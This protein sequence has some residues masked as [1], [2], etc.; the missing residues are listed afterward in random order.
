[1]ANDN[2]YA[3]LKFCNEGRIQICWSRDLNLDAGTDWHV[4]HKQ[5]TFFPSFFLFFSKMFSN[6][7]GISRT[8][9]KRGHQIFVKVIIFVFVFVDAGAVLWDV[10]SHPQWFVNKNRV[11]HLL[12]SIGNIIPRNFICYLFIYFQLKF[13]G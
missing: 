8:Q 9:Q 3:N 5:D 10:K 2:A 7:F 11:D 13:F 12:A 1:M 6:I 4:I